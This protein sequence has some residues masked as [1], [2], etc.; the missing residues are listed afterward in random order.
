[1]LGR[2]MSSL[3]ALVV[4][5]SGI[6][7]A[8]VP[9]QAR[10]EGR[11]FANERSVSTA[12]QSKQKMRYCHGERAT[13]TGNSR[14]NRLFGTRGRD[15]IWAGAGPD[16]VVGRGGNDLICGGQGGDVLVGSNGR[17]RLYGGP[18]KDLC[19][20]EGREHRHHH[21]C[22]VH[23][24]PFG[25]VVDPPSAPSKAT[26]EMGTEA[27]DPAVPERAG[28]YFDVDVPLCMRDVSFPTVRFG[29]A[30]FKT[31]YTQPG[32]I[33]ILPVYARWHAYGG[34]GENLQAAGD[35]QVYYAPS[36]NQVYKVDL[37]GF[38]SRNLKG[39]ETIWGYYVYWWDGTQW[40]SGRTLAIINFQMPTNV[41]RVNIGPVCWT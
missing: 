9:A 27:Y 19:R 4:A 24:N 30:Y 8:S 23:S 3:V 34:Y 29:N 7:L 35:W 37:L 11:A 13:L 5:A 32:Y 38:T 25:D 17:D 18:H 16:L 1:M 26:A 31:Y 36:D 12:P 33:A 14:T 2:T 10:D 40:V 22:E 15:V 39:L 21:G 20:G 41:G 28:E 6:G